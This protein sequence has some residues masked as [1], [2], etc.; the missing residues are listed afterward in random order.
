VNKNLKLSDSIILSDIQLTD[1][2]LKILDLLISSESIFIDKSFSIKDEISLTEFVSVIT[3][4]LKQVVDS[5]NLEDLVKTDKSLIKIDDFVELTEELK[6]DKSIILQDIFS[7]IDIA[8]VVSKIIP[9]IT[10]PDVKFTVTPYGEYAPDDTVGVFAQLLD[11]EGKAV[12]NANIKLTLY[13]LNGNPVTNYEDL[14]MD[15]IADSKGLYKLSFRAPSTPGIYV[16]GVIATWDSKKAFASG[17]I[18]VSN[19]YKPPRFGFVI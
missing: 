3:Y 4:I 1:K 14:D 19:R 11:E 7:L 18:N 15:Y 9:E 2:E 10:S 5:L 6:I 17:V 16:Y 8:E 13:N 12:N